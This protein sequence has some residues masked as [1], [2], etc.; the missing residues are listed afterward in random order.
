VAAVRTDGATHDEILRSGAGL[1][2]ETD[3]PDQ[4]LEAI[5]RLYR[6]PCLCGELADAG[7][8]YASESLA[9]APALA[10]AE[11]FIN[12]LLLGSKLAEAAA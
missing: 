3:R 10:R 1:L 5:D 8:N 2:V 6:D 11:E 12:R 4:L 7:R 9:A